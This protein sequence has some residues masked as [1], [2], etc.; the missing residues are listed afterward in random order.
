M[1]RGS[2][3]LFCMMWYE[4]RFQRASNIVA[5]LF[6]LW[7]LLMLWG[8]LL[9]ENVL[10]KLVSYQPASFI[11]VEVNE[12]PDIAFAPSPPGIHKLFW[13]FITKLHIISAP[14]PLPLNPIPRWGG[15]RWPWRRSVPCRFTATLQEVSHA[16]GLGHSVCHASCCDGIDECCFPDICSKRDNAQCH[17]NSGAE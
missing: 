5:S 11:V 14:P 3:F 10:K 8:L 1:A 2:V 17:Q 15:W 9:L 7:K 6:F 13:L 4:G 16:A 12:R